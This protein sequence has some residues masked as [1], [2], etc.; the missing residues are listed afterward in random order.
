MKLT[1][2]LYSFNETVQHTDTV[3]M[4]LLQYCGSWNKKADSV[5]AV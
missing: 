3:G 2:Y 4:K 1:S 5:E